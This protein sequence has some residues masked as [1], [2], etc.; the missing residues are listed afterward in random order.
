MTTSSDC[1]NY[2]ASVAVLLLGTTMAFSTFLTACNQLRM[3]TSPIEH[4]DF[5]RECPENLHDEEETRDE[6]VTEE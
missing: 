4:Y 2:S 6:D 1:L 5:V 3:L